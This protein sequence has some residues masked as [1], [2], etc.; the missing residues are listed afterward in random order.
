M[1]K[2]SKK[3]FTLIELLTVIAILSIL[4][5]LIFGNFV[6]TIKKARDNRRKQDLS[7]VKTALELYFAEVGFYPTTHPT[8]EGGLPWGS[9]LTNSLGTKTYMKKLPQ[10]PSRNNGYNYSYQS[11]GTYFKLYSCLE[12]TEDLDYNNITPTGTPNCGVGCNNQC[13]YGVS[14]P[15]I[16][17]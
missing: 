14:S 15:N 9:A 2:L 5:A 16:V 6:T 1:Q 3:G 8:E 10:E 13:N 7:Q 11:D 12:N 4:A 17:P